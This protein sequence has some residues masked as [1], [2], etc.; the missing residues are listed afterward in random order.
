MH[1]EIISKNLIIKSI[2][3]ILSYAIKLT[4]YFQYQIYR[5]YLNNI[6]NVFL[7]KNWF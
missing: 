7:T 6:N 1:D 5:K 4:V 2:G 3:C